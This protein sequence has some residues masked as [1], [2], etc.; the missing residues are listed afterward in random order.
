MVDEYFRRLT[1]IWDGIA[2]CLNTKRCECGKCTCDLNVAH[3]KETE[4]LRVDDF[5][6]GLDDSVHGVVR[7][8]LCAITLLHDLDSIYQTVLKNRNRNM[9]KYIKF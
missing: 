5:L 8:Q 1:K 9:L 3:E 6:A 7:S 2:E 4:I